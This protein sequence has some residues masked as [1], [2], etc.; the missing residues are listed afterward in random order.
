ML[1]W[2]T[3]RT[4]EDDQIFSH[5]PNH[6]ILTQHIRPEVYTT[7]IKSDNKQ[8]GSTYYWKLVKNQVCVFV[9]GVSNKREKVRA[10]VCVC[11]REC[12]VD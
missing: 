7:D 4:D 9:G 6:S 2:S 10:C 1:F 8:N 5:H 3:W 12:L 11:V